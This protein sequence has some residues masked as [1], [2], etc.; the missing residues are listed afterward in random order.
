MQRGGVYVKKNGEWATAAAAVSAAGGIGIASGRTVIFFFAQM[1]W[2]SWFG[3][4]AASVLFGVLCGAVAAA[5]SET[6]CGSFD[7]SCRILAGKWTA[8]I[9]NLLMMFVAAVM[10]AESGKL[11]MLA[12]P[13]RKAFWIG[14]VASLGL[15]SL[16]C[17]RGMQTWGIAAIFL[18]ALFYVLMALD[19]RPVRFAARY[20]TELMLRDSMG[21]ALLL[22]MLHAAVSASAAAGSMISYT[23]ESPWKPAWKAGGLMLLLLSAVNAAILRGGER[24]FSRPE[25]A[26]LLAARWGKAGY[27]GCILVKWMCTLATLNASLCALAGKTRKRRKS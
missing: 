9:Y 22:S 15:S 19:P 24:L 4:L 13:I 8:V 7:G 10:L 20:E 14:A 21:A 6:G 17:I 12:L 16:L 18:C 27:Y 26:V 1:G 3:I 5:A 25:P 11:A 2:A 23:D